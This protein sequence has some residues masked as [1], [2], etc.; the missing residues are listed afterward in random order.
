MA[1]DRNIL[2]SL[3]LNSRWTRFLRFWPFCRH[4]TLS[5]NMSSVTT[6]SPKEE[7]NEVLRLEGLVVQTRLTHVETTRYLVI[8]FH[9]GSISVYRKPPL[10]DELSSLQ[11]TSQSLPS[12]F[13]SSVTPSP[14]KRYKSENG[15]FENLAHISRQ[16]R[17]FVSGV[18]EPKFTVSSSVDWKLR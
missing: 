4:C 6:H 18:W 9:A 2:N 17:H 15:A 1:I 5:A 8:D 3:A 14:L 12:K 16:H 13:L 11:T 7:K 10:S